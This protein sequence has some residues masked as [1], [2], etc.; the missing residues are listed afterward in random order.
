MYFT[1]EIYLKFIRTVVQEK[2]AQNFGNLLTV[3]S[4][5]NQDRKQKM[6]TNL[7]VVKNV[8]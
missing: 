5:D 8:L 6:Q 4:Q 2:A 1:G 3:I 7:D